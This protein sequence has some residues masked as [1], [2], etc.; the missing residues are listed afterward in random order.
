MKL[1]KRAAMAALL[2]STMVGGFAS[3]KGPVCDPV[4]YVIYQN[5]IAR[6]GVLCER[7]LENCLAEH[8]T[9]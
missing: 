7:Q 1:I 4:C 9:P 5:C 6:G 3:S 8:C 2:T